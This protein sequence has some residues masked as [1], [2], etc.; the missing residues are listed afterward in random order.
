M[1]HGLS[2]TSQTSFNIHTRGCVGHR[3]SGHWDSLVICSLVLV[4]Y[5]SRMR[6]LYVGG[7]GEISYACVEAAARAGAGRDRLQPRPKRR[8]PAA[9]VEAISR[10]AERRDLSRLGRAGSTSSANSSPTTP[11]QIERDLEDL[12]R[13]RG[14]VPLHLH[15]FRLP[16]TADAT[17]GSPNRRPCANP[18][19]P[20]SQTKADMEAMLFRWHAQG[21]LPVTVV[22][23][24]HTY[25]RRS[26]ERSSAATTTS[27][28]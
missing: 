6:I 2:T 12:R 16:E 13:A 27:G 3:A 14:S 5:P 7:T 23:P 8:A 19:W 21:K 28:G 9:G 4:R 26:R 15:R 11:T 17:G 24:S 18:Y 1:R 25:R 20:Y 22:R 10:R